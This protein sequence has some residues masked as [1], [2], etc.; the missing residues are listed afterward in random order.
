MATAIVSELAAGSAEG[1]RISLPSM[2]LVDPSDPF[3][4]PLSRRLAIVFSVAA[5]TAF[6]LFVAREGLWFAL[7]AGALVFCFWT[8]LINWQDT[9]NPPKT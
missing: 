8:F 4:R 3:Y 7:A 6:E 5:W 9:P 2:K 1:K